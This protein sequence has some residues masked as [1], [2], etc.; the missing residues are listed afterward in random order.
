MHTR[1][2]SVLILGLA[3]AAGCGPRLTDA[4]TEFV[5]D[6][7]GRVA[8]LCGDDELKA[9]DRGDFWVKFLTQHDPDWSVD[10]SD[11]V[12]EVDGGSVTKKALGRP[13]QQADGMWARFETYWIHADADKKAGDVVTVGP[14]RHTLTRE[15]HGVRTVESAHCVAVVKD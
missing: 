1:P 13:T 5:G 14:L 3:V 7:H 4:P 2:A 15:G 11:G 10:W 6:H 9:G 12:L 8:T